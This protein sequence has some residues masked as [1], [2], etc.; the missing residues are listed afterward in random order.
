MRTQL[1]EEEAREQQRAKHQQQLIQKQQQQQQHLLQQQ[2][3]A[4]QQQQRTTQQT[5]VRC[6]PGSQ[7]IVTSSSLPQ[8]Q[9]I[10]VMFLTLTVLEHIEKIW[11][12]Y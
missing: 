4:Q 11:L 6:I 2:R 8:S 9:V 3:T 1:Q 7:T 10:L 12:Q 5:D